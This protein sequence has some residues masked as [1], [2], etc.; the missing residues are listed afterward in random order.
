MSLQKGRIA[1]SLVHDAVKILKFEK[2]FNTH[3]TTNAERFRWGLLQQFGIANLGD[4]MKEY[5]KGRDDLIKQQ[6]VEMGIRILQNF[7]KSWHEAIASINPE[8]WSQDG[9]VQQYKAEMTSLL[10]STCCQK[11]RYKV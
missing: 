3:K 2:V 1:L 7:S 8:E 5:M 4:Q 11:S 9:D 6:Q 10:R